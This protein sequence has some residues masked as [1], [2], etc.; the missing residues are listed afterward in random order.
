MAKKT[1]EKLGKYIN[2]F[3]DFGFK[4]LFGEEA[5]KKLLIN[6]LNTLL[7]DVRITKIKYLK[8]EHLGKQE[9]DRKSIF[10]LYCQNE[11]GEHFIIEMQKAKQKYFKDR[12]VFYAS[13]V[14]LSQAKKD[15]KAEKGSGEPDFVWNYELANVYT[16]AVMDFKFDMIGEESEGNQVKHDVMLLNIETNKI[17]YD[18]LRFVYLEMPN[19]NKTIEQLESDY[20]K[21][22][23]ILKNISK[24]E[25]APEILNQGIFM[26]VFEIAEVANYSPEEMSA[27]EDSLKSYRDLKNSMITY[28]EEGLQKGEII[29]LQK[30][31]IIGLQKGEV[32]GLQKG[33]QKGAKETNK[34]NTINCIHL[35]LDN[36]TIHQITNLPIS[37]IEK[38]RKELSK[39]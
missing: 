32:I 35:G 33:L 20:D 39:K 8:N 7:V 16:I 21:W 14:I 37:E 2:F 36:Q 17:F 30:G 18:K 28:R 3:T 34:M 23:Y 29:G 1:E 27:Y 24:F 11:K 13:S 9:K 19:F 10:D 12:G 26:E 15:K 25:D 31:E 6:F 4:K 5:N 22:L 38:I